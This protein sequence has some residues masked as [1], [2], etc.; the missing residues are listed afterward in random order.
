[1]KKL[2]FA[3]VF[4]CFLVCS[5]KAQ[6]NY[7]HTELLEGTGTHTIIGKEEGLTELHLYKDNTLRIVWC[8]GKSIG[9]CESFA[10]N[11]VK[12]GKNYILTF[13]VIH[14][15][16]SIDL[17]LTS[18]DLISFNTESI[19]ISDNSGNEIKKD[20]FWNLVILRKINYKL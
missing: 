11:W 1:M 2:I 5:L 4:L 7:Y 20:G 16:S 18:P 17:K 3:T 14:K 12:S 8:V 19:T 6:S 13:S 9:N 10:G 15:E